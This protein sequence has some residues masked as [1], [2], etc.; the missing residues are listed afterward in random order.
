M[1]FIKPTILRDKVAT[2]Y[3]TNEKYQFIRDWQLAE[4]DRDRRLFPDLTPPTLP[5]LENETSSEPGVIDLRELP[6]LETM[7]GTVEAEG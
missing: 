6:A 2:S 7:P 3:A 5:E 1:V 4:Q